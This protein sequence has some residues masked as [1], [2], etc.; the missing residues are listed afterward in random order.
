MSN[1]KL[2]LLEII[3]YHF[4]IATE[5]AGVYIYGRFV[6]EIYGNFKKLELNF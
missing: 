1:L 4:S 3:I 5:S 2:L 6:G